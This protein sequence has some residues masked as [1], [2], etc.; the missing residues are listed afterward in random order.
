MLVYYLENEL[1]CNGH[2]FLVFFL[3]RVDNLSDVISGDFVQF[4]YPDSWG[5]C[6]IVHST[7][8]KNDTIKLYSLFPSTNGYG[9]QEFDIPTYCFFCT[10]KRFLT[11]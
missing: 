6:G 7:D 10:V 9:I 8:L 3:D 11:L 2:K 5:H 1:F 4:W